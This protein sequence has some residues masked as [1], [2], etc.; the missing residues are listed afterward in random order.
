MMD[1]LEEKGIIGP[2]E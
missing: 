1:I 2:Q